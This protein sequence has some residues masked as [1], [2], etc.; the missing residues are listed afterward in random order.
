MNTIRALNTNGD[1]GFGTLYLSGPISNVV[2]STGNYLTSLAKGNV[3]FISS[4]YISLTPRREL[5]S[6]NSFLCIPPPPLGWYLPTP[7]HLC[8]IA[9]LLE[10]FAARGGLRKK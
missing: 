1:I 3:T 5:V 9:A 8:L 2:N 7:S 6:A 4:D 10:Q